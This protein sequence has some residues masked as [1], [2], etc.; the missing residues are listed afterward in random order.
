MSFV[1]LSMTKEKSQFIITY[2]MENILNFERLLSSK[3]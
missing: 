2:I 1:T 3:K